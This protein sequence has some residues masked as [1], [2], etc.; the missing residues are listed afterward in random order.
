MSNQVNV[1]VNSRKLLVRKHEGEFNSKES[2]AKV[3]HVHVVFFWGFSR[4]DL[5][6]YS[7]LKMTRRP[8]TPKFA[9]LLR[10]VGF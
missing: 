4:S 5:L 6:F 9:S 1:N 8:I 2:A 7:C 3:S 10:S